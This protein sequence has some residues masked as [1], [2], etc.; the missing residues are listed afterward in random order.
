VYIVGVYSDGTNVG[1]ITYEPAESC[2]ELAN[3]RAAQ[4]VSEPGIVS[5]WRQHSCQPSPRP[6]A[7]PLRPIGDEAASQLAVIAQEPTGTILAILR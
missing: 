3:C 6:V 4:V 2:A 1:T 5:D 7:P